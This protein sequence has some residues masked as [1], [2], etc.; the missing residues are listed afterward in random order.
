M[1]RAATKAFDWPHHR[2]QGNPVNIHIFRGTGNNGGEGLVLA[3]I[4][5]S[6]ATTWSFS[7][8]ARYSGYTLPI[9]SRI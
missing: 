6:T 8:V 7:E 3:V 1:E 9:S 4:W 2:L 5:R